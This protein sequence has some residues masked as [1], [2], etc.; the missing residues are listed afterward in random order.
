MIVSKSIKM[1]LGAPIGA[2]SGKRK[3]GRSVNYIFP[4]LH[5]AKM[6]ILV[7]N[8]NDS[9]HAVILPR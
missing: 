5:K 9:N 4:K 6:V 3:S 7:K 1:E 2:A 8:K